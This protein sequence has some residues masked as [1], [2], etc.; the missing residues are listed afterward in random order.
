MNTNNQIDPCWKKDFPIRQSAE[1][2]ISRRQ[3]TRFFG[4][5]S[6]TLL[7]G[8]CVA[9]VTRRF[10]PAQ[11]KQ[12]PPLAVAKIDELKIGG[13]KLFRYPTEESRC[14]LMRLGPEKYVAL[15]QSCTH[16]QCP[17]HFQA[18]T[19][20]MFCPCHNGF[21]SAEDGRVLSGPPPRPLPRYPVEIRDGQIWV[22]PSKTTNIPATVRAKPAQPSIQKE[23][24]SL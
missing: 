17:V 21:F 13:Y 16:L 10:F 1:H 2:E 8:V 14:I 4:V 5:A 24:A 15:S 22:W 7:A 20:K 23:R 3:F 11:T 6:L 19:K 18:D 12:I 9:S